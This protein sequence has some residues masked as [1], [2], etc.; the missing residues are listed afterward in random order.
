MR[1]TRK[2]IEIIKEVI[3]RYVKAEIYIFGSRVNDNV[4]GG[5]VDIFI[6][7]LK[8]LSSSKELE[9]KIKIKTD[10]EENLFMPVDIVFDKKERL[11]DKIAKK[12]VLI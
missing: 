5:D 4:K 12:G 7:P 6:T 11:I 2:E 3:D 8:K 9:L 10:L 1:L